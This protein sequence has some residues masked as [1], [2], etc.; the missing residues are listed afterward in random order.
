LLVTASKAGLL[1]LV[2]EFLQPRK[3][4]PDF[5]LMALPSSP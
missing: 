4:S 3:G 2:D 5:V 1:G